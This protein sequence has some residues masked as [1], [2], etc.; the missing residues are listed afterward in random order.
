VRLP[1]SGYSFSRSLLQRA[2]KDAGTYVALVKFLLRA[3][4]VSQGSWEDL[5]STLLDIVSQDSGPSRRS[6][7]IDGIEQDGIFCCNLLREPLA[8]LRGWPPGERRAAIE[9]GLA[10][11]RPDAPTG[12]WSPS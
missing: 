5:L 12:A 8:T 3:C 1:A 2:S 6:M 7:L 10:G 4:Y 9:K 11:W